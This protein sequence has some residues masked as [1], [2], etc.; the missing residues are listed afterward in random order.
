MN[1][2][3][4]HPSYGKLPTQTITEEEYTMILDN[5]LVPVVSYKDEPALPKGCVGVLRGHY[6]FLEKTR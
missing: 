5:S 1:K 2:A 3:I 4:N 6:I